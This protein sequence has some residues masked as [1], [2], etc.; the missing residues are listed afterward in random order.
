MAFALK[1]T[2]PRAARAPLVV[3]AAKFRP[4]SKIGKKPI[5]IPK[6]VKVTLKDHHLTVKARC[7]FL[8]EPRRRCRQPRARRPLTPHPWARGSS[9]AG[10]PGYSFVAARSRT[11][12][13]PSSG[14]VRPQRALAVAWPGWLGARARGTRTRA[15]PAA[16]ERG[17]FRRAPRASCNASSTRWCP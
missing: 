3:Y 15:S 2:A 6:T 9:G 11:P 10:Q 5:S 17:C 14:A 7:A 8:A 16:T 4:Q 12:P 1:A 13:T